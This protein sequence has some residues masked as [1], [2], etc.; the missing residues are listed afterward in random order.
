MGVDR[1]S[2]HGNLQVRGMRAIC[3]N[4]KCREVLEELRIAD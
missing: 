3:S 4:P 1:T 2:T